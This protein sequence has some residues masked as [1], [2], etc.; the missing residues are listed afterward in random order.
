MISIKKQLDSLHAKMDMLLSFLSPKA[1]TLESQEEKKEIKK[2]SLGD[3]IS[4]TTRANGM[5][6][7]KKK[8]E[9][10]VE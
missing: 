3:M 6:N 9:E 5:K 10:I 1:N 8:D 4:K 2:V 7:S